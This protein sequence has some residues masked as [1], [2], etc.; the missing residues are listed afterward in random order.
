[1]PKKQANGLY[2][3]K[4]KIGVDAHGKSVFKW[5]SGK[6]KREL[7]EARARIIDYYIE[8]AERPDDRLFGD[9]AVEWYQLRKKPFVSPSQQNAYR[10]MLNKYVLPAFG[11]RNLRAIRAADLQRFVNSFAGSSASQIAMALSVLHGVFAAAFA[12]RILDADPSVRLQRPVHTP[13]KE[14]RALTPDERAGIERAIATQPDSE[15]L[16]ILYYT[17]MRPGEARGLQW[18]D[19]DWDSNMIHVQRDLDFVTGDYG[20]LKTRAA[21][22][23]IPIVPPLREYLHPRRGLSD[24]PVVASRNGKPI[25]SAT[26][27]RRW[28]ALMAAAGMAEEIPDGAS[29]YSKR[30]IRSGAR[31]TIT[32]HALRHNFVTMCWDMGMDVQLVAKIV[33][34][35]DIN[36]TMAIYTHLDKSHVAAAADQLGAMFA[37]ESAQNKKVAQKLHNA[38][39]DVVSIKRKK[40]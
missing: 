9:Y 22:R 11:D 1:M 13:P 8:G 30:D 5:I 29:R 40:A 28:I 37:A 31:A 6:T 33:G 2:R 38:P 20:E 27:A 39:A 4:V 24:A 23:Y 21:N 3:T 7:E 14:K 12:D 19:I 18:G 17:G 25:T 15:Y 32:P 35:S 34:H 36:V 16:A 26:A 10:T